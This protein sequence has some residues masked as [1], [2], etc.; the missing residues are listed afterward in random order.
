MVDHAMPA[1]DAPLSPAV[2]RWRVGLLAVGV[3]LLGVG[4]VLLALDLDPAEWVGLVVWLALALVVHDGLIAFGVFGVQLLLRRAGRRMPV[5]VVAIAQGAVVIGA[6]IA[7][8]VIPQI[9]KRAIGAS[10]P[11]VVPLDYGVNLMVFLV[12]LIIT[13]A[14][15][16]GLYLLTVARR[17]NVR[18]SST[19][20]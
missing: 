20:D 11:T 12:V 9:Y 19:Q 4:G 10:N 15:V 13:T 8:V 18:P 6:I 2:R 7:L 5:V 17:Q 14:V 1:G 3:G 16:I